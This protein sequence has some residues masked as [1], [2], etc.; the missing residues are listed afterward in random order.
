MSAKLPMVE[1]TQRELF[2]PVPITAVTENIL[3]VT[4]KD[5]QRISFKLRTNSKKA[6][7]V[8]PASGFLNPGEEVMIKFTLSP[9][10][11]LL[12]T[13][14]ESTVASPTNGASSSGEDFFL[15]QV[16]FV[17]AEE[18]NATPQEFWAAAATAPNGTTLRIS[19]PCKYIS[20]SAIPR[21][22]VIRNQSGSRGSSA[23]SHRRTPREQQQDSGSGSGS[24]TASPSLAA[25][26]LNLTPKVTPATAPLAQTP[27][28]TNNSSATCSPAAAPLPLLA[29][30]AHEAI[31]GGGGVVGGGMMHRRG[32]SRKDDANSAA[33]GS[34]T[35]TAAT[36]V[37]APTKKEEKEEQQKGGGNALVALISYRIPV[38][39]VVVLMLLAYSFALF[40]GR[41]GG[42]SAALPTTAE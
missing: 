35:T 34:S 16:R 10:A 26:P 25:S 33:E 19:M 20:Q 38:P 24:N 29:G 28:P 7:V 9:Q 22:M 14:S 21:S 18:T 30:E 6:F 1:L 4:N 32:S 39:V 8:R 13:P 37:A 42:R 3:K 12:P 36:A 40:G 31:S 2:Y 27:T 5:R 15:M 23:H 11:A 41:S 17:S